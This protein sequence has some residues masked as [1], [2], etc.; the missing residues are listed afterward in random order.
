[1]RIFSYGGPESVGSKIDY[2][3]VD[4]RLKFTKSL[5]TTQ[6]NY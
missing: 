4:R 5:D 3:G 2:I 6:W 1:M